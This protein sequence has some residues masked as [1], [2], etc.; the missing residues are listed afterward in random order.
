MEKLSANMKVVPAIIACPGTVGTQTAVVVDGTG[1]DRVAFVLQMGTAGAG[2]TCAGKVQNSDA[3]GGTYADYTSAAFASITKAA[4]D[5][6]A[7]MIDVPVVAASPFMKLICT[8]ATADFPLA[9]VAI[10]YKGSRQYPVTA[11]TTQTVVL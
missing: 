7:E 10:L 8:T 11:G 2:G 1:F 6:K 5:G 3:T 4:G 9:A